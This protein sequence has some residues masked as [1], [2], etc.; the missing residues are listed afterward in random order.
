MP[1]TLAIIQARMGSSRLPGKVLLDIAGQPMLARVVGRAKR[2][3]MLSGIVVATTTEVQD[4][5]VAALCQERAYPLYRGSLHD[6]LD[7]YYQAARQFEA[8]IVVR[9][10]ADCPVIDPD[11]VDETVR[12][13]LGQPGIGNPQPAFDFAATRLPPPWRRTYPI[14]L[15][16]ET[17]TFAALERA[18]READQPFH[19]EHVMPYLYEGVVLDASP[20][21]QVTSSRGFKIAVLNHDPGCGFL[22]WTVDTAED[23]EL[24]RQ[25]YARFGGRDDFSWKEVLALFES[26]PELAKVNAKIQ[27][28]TMLDVEGKA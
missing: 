17:C 8:E 21:A 19:R 27:H 25:V 12:V 6:V 22:R 10:T 18:W 28:K 3:G 26:D 15:D 1:R 13:L 20:V 4:D 16:V 24:I 11:L 14:G 23:L 7:R 2:A 5:A 9:I